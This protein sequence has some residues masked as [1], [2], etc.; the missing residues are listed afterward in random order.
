M[1]FEGRGHMQ[2]VNIVAAE[3]IDGDGK[4]WILIQ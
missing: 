4:Q 3:D 1:T 2:F